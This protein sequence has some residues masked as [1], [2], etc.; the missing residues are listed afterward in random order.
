M[1]NRLPVSTIRDLDVEFDAYGF[2]VKILNLAFALFSRDNNKMDQASEKFYLWVDLEMTGLDPNLDHIMELAMLVTDNQ[3]ELVSEKDFHAY[4]M[5]EPLHGDKI[6]AKKQSL[7]ARNK[8]PASG[9]LGRLL[10]LLNEWCY[11]QYHNSDAFGNL[12][13][14]VAQ[15]G[16]HLGKVE[17]EVLSYLKSIKVLDRDGNPTAKLLLAGNSVYVD[18]SFLQR[19]MPK[20][21]KLLHYRIIDVSTVKE[22]CRDVNSKIF[23]RKPEKK[24]CHRATDDILESL[25]ELRYYRYNFFRTDSPEK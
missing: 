17:E 24:L 19:H 16:S 20:L 4:I 7:F 12:I 14:T 21:Y 23:D 8:K 15:K 3:L 6:K 1:E 25:E 9:K 18:K 10:E 11:Q 2:L 22:L 5:P 13:E